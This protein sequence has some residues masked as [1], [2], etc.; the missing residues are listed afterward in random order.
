MLVTET[1]VNDFKTGDFVFLVGSRK[2]GVK[3][4]LLWWPA[5]RWASWRHS[6]IRNIGW[7]TCRKLT[8]TYSVT[9]EDLAANSF[10]PWCN[11]A[12]FYHNRCAPLSGGVHSYSVLCFG[13]LLFYCRVSFSERLR[14][15]RISNLFLSFSLPALGSGFFWYPTSP[16]TLIF[17]FGIW[18]AFFLFFFNSISI[19]FSNQNYGEEYCA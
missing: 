19:F 17:L 6:L 3:L 10:S 14:W 4:L 13:F 15:S 11:C 2:S 1:N 12:S 5:L 9:K 8:P 18:F 7:R 16:W